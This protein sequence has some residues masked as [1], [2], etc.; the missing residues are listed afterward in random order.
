MSNRKGLITRALRCSGKR[1]R[2]DVARVAMARRQEQHSRK[3]SRKQVYLHRAIQLGCLRDDHVFGEVPGGLLKRGLVICKLEAEPP[4]RSPAKPAR[5]HRRW[6]AACT[7]SERPAQAHRQH[8]SVA[9]DEWL[10][11]ALEGTRER[12]YCGV[13]GPH[14]ENV[15]LCRDRILRFSKRG[16]K[17]QENSPAHRNTQCS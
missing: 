16:G 12:T 17:K 11:Q 2:S 3:G 14:R 15:F 8:R 5:Q 9:Y 1:E 6:G 7:A 4:P 10:E 13:R